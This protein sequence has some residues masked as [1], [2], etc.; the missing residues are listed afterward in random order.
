MQNIKKLFKTT[1]TKS[2][3]YS[4]GMTVIIIAIIVAANMIFGQLP[5]KFRNID[6]SSTKIYEISDKS[7]EILKDLDK[8]ITFTVL[9][10]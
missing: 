9:A 8:D 1:G 10:E 5:E 4:V 3:T 7:R 2:G 6:V